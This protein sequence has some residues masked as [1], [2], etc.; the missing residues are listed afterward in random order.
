MMPYFY[1]PYFYLNVTPIMNVLLST[2]T[3][4]TKA[5][6]SCA[7]LFDISVRHKQK[8]SNMED[9]GFAMGKCRSEREE[10]NMA[11]AEMRFF[12][13]ISSR[14]P[15]SAASWGRCKLPAG[16]LWVGFRPPEVFLTF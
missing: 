5:A 10:L 14:V 9:L 15:S 12:G 16:S 2:L 13:T 3:D 1:L 6:A 11:R 8:L 7:T 4:G